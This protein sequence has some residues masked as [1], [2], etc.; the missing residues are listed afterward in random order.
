[1]GMGMG[2]QREGEIFGVLLCTLLRT[3]GFVES[4][5]E[6]ADDG[7]LFFEG[8]E[9]VGADPCV[10]P[11]MFFV[12]F[13]D[14]VD[15]QL[16]LDLLVLEVGALLSQLV[17]L[18][19]ELGNALLRLNVLL[20]SEGHRTTSSA[21]TSPLIQRLVGRY[22]HLQLVPHPVQ[23]QSSFR[24]AY[25]HLPDYLVKRLRKQ[26]LPHRADPVVASLSFG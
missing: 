14:G 1:M 25:R 7:A 12:L 11:S 23:H 26:L 2:I 15:L 18:L 16:E 10:D 3:R 9:F 8:V 4:E 21:A 5:C 6:L 13:F 20:Q 22:R 19:L 24:R 17:Q